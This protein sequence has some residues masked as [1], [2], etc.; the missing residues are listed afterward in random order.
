MHSVLLPIGLITL[1]GLFR[2]TFGLAMKYIK[3]LSAA[4]SGSIESRLDSYFDTTV[5]SQP[6][7]FQF[8]NMCQQ[9]CRTLAVRDTKFKERYTLRFRAELFIALNH[10]GFG[11]PNTTFGGPAFGVISSINAS[12]PARI[13]QLALKLYF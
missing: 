5:F 1:T 13:V 12:A 6:A 4:R 9:H 7:P 10:P 8:G 11:L 2:R 3:P